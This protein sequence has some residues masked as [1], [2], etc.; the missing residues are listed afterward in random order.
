MNVLPAW[1]SC[2]NGTGVT[3]GV[4]DKGVQNHTD[5]NIVSTLSYHPCWIYS[6]KFFKS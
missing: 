2:F 6:W 5:L 3:V 4:V 1:E